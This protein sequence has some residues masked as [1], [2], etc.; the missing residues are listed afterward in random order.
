MPVVTLISVPVPLDMRPRLVHALTD[1]AQEALLLPDEHRASIAVH[2]VLLDATAR[3]AGQATPGG[4]A[5]DYLLQ[6][7][8]SG[9]TVEHEA[10]L[11]RVL[12]PALLQAL[13]LDPGA[14]ITVAVAVAPVVSPA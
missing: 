3:T 9:I 11:E 7:T 5:P 14:V 10:A 6:V 4:G 1:A 12:V 8:G 2:F 13:E